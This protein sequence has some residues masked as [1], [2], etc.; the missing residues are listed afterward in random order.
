MLVTAWLQHPHVLPPVLN[1]GTKDGLLYSVMPDAQGE[2]LRARF[3]RERQLR[4][5][6]VIAQRPQCS[7]APTKC[8]S[9][10]ARR[11]DSMHPRHGAAV[12]Q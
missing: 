3:K 11:A 7:A 8:R 12:T 2:S 1:A 6:E 10:G 4:V 9:V 5:D